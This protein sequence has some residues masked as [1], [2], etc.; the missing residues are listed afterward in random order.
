MTQFL[1]DSFTGASNTFL[2]AHVGELG[3]AWQ[4]CTAFAGSQAPRFDP[5]GLRLMSYGGANQLLVSSGVAGADGA[6]AELV[7]DTVTDLGSIGVGVRCSL[8]AGYFVHIGG[9]IA[10]VLR[11]DAA[12]AFTALTLSTGGTSMAKTQTV[13]THTLRATATGTGANVVIT[14]TYDGVVMFT[15][16]DSSAGRYTALGSAG[17]F[18]NGGD[19]T[20][21]HH[22]TS[23]SGVAP[24]AAA[25]TIAPV[26]TSPTGTQTGGT[27]ASGSVSTDEGAGTLYRYAST[28]ATETAATIKAAALTSTVTATGVQNGTFAGLTPSTTYYAHYVQDDAAP[29]PNTSTVANSTSFTTAAAADT[30]APVLSLPLGAQTGSSTASGGATTN[31]ANGTLYRLASI[32]ATETAATIKAAALTSTVTATGAQATSFTG[33][34]PST[35]YYAHY[36][37]RD[38]AGNDSNVV[39]SAA[40]TT[41]AA[42]GITFAVTAPATGRIYQRSAQVAG[43]ASVTVT[44]TMSAT[45]TTIQA[46]LVLEGT[47]TAVAGFDWATRVASPSGTAFTFALAAVPQGAVLYEVQLRDSATPATVTTAGKFGVGALVAIIGQSQPKQWFYVGDSTL[48]PSP[49]IRVYGNMAAGWNTPP[50]ATANGAISFGNA[51]TAALGVVVGMLDYSW[52]G[53]GMII[54]NSGGQWVPIS[55]NAYVAFK[56][57]ATGVTSKLEAAVWI[58]G[59]TESKLYDP[60]LVQND[61]Y[62]GLGTL[63]A[64]IRTDFNNATMPIVIALLGT[65]T[66]GQVPDL[67]MDEVRIAQA[68]KGIEA[69]TYRVERSDIALSGDGLHHSATGHT[70]LAKRCAQPI[71]YALGAAAYWR[72]PRISSATKPT[73]TAINV[74][75]AHGGGSDFTP[76]SGITGWRVMDGATPVTVTAAVR[77]SA[78]VIQLTLAGTPGASLTVDYL[79]G[80]APVISGL[81]KDNTTLTLPLEFA[82]PV[83]MAALATTVSFT[84][85]DAAGVPVTGLTGLDYAFFDQPRISNAAAPVKKGATLAISAGVATVDITGVTTLNVGQTGRI[86]WGTADGTKAG[87]GQVVVS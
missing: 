68:R 80:A 18:M 49:S 19:E 73:T 85:V 56:S 75:L 15:A 57:G 17:L 9:G 8:T 11:L 52:D 59:E 26:L 31:E 66:D 36:V 65:R 47:N 53:S 78:T 22:P 32:N 23:I 1:N 24:D 87:G 70:V 21:G 3:A 13:G 4:M 41:A 33:L 5:T 29:T 20:S 51:L 63:F 43:T 60:A 34:T 72:G 76:T 55:S 58:Q 14:A 12:G 6:Y 50:T 83:S 54:T 28:N 82:G 86:Q 81:A 39:N 37:H 2:T 42:A 27:T 69:N 61:Y 67:N 48:T 46:R 77:L 45:P 40:F 71:A 30:T 64:G 84:V 25:D 16:T 35:L 74:T 38:A 79:H 10:R 44:G 7:Y 62:A